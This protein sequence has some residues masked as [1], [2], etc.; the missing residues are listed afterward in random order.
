MRLN[1]ALGFLLASSFGLILGF[2][3]EYTDTRLR[4]RIAVEDSTGIPVLSMIPHLKS[5]DPVI[6]VRLTALNG[7]GSTALTPEW[8]EER[9]LALEAFRTLSADLRFVAR[10]LRNGGIRSVAVTSAARGE[11]KTY[12]SCNVAIARAS[13]G[14]RTLLVDGD[15]RGRGVSRFLRLPL[16]IPG[17]T[18]VMTSEVAFSDVVQTLEVGAGE[19]LFLLPAGSATSHSAALLESEEFSRLIHTAMSR[20]DFVVIDTPPLN[21]VTDTAAV[22]ALVDGMVVVVRAGVTDRLAL[23][24]TLERLGRAGAHIAGIALNDVALPSHYRTYSHEG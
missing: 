17:L 7:E 15:L 13:H 3:K 9:E 14:A 20:F 4:E 12:T 8:S 5:P 18:E 24:L 6:S 19:T 1:L 16:D 21:V 23:E 10:G 2:W 22:A 11:G